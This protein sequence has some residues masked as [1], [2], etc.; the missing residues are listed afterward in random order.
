MYTAS[1]TIGHAFNCAFEI[2]KMSIE[3][4]HIHRNI[5]TL[6]ASFCDVVY[7]IECIHSTIT[8][9]PYIINETLPLRQYM[10][11]FISNGT[12]DCLALR[13]MINR[14]SSSFSP[15]I[16]FKTVGFDSK[17]QDVTDMYNECNRLGLLTLDISPAT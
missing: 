11:N 1:K 9:F 10:D 5:N 3:C 15:G 6:F 14:F 2:M 12:S 8:E 13:D 16:F 17:L 7:I 4:F